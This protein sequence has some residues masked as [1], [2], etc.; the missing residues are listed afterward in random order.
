MNSKSLSV[1]IL[2]LFACSLSN[3]ASLPTGAIRDA[4][5][6][7]G[8][9]IV[10]VGCGGGR[11]TVEL[12]GNTGIIVH[13]LDSDAANVERARGYIQS[14]GLYGRV[15]VEQFDGKNLPYIDNL[16]NMIIAENTKLSNKE[17]LRALRPLG[18]A[19]IN[20]KKTVKELTLVDFPFMVR[21][22]CRSQSSCGHRA[23]V[24]PLM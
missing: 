20:G 6:M 2:F 16:V 17:I 8:G 21:L 11:S 18:T 22:L 14:I 3:A 12:C 13:A 5:Q 9:L 10:H 23:L 15:S 19:Y 24:L 1:I 7:Q 4:A